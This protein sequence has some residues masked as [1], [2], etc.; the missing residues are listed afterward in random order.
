MKNILVLYTGGTIG[1][2]RD[3][4]KGSLK[5]VDFKKLIATFPELKDAKIHIEYASLNYAIDSSNMN[6][7]YWFQIADYINS[8]YKE[9]DGIVILHGT[10]TMAYTA[11]AISFMLYGVNKAIIFTGSQ[12]PIGDRRTDAKENLITAIEIAASGK[13]SEVCIFFENELFRANRTVKVNSEHFEA[14]VSPNYP[15]LAKVGVN[16]KYNISSIKKKDEKEL[17]FFENLT[18]DIA[19]LKLFPA[20]TK[21]VVKAVLNSAKVI[22]LE[23]YGAGNA[24]NTKWFLDCLKDAIKKNKLI[25]NCSQCLMGSVQQG[26]YETSSDLE[27]IG[28]IS[29]KDMTTEATVTKLM[30]ICAQGYTRAEILEL[31]ESDYRGELTA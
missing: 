30:H 29:A 22:I 24:P 8:Y 1:M 10:D 5:A 7:D 2:Q 25:V 20:I 17:C 3:M 6:M 9:V 11:S 12:I 27:K 31:F 26:K 14:F 16:I 18:D 4:K 19:I 21:K 13:I 23:T 28:V 15:L